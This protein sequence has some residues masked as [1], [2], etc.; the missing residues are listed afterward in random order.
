M[1]W[2]GK[3]ILSCRLNVANLRRSKYKIWR[4]NGKPSE[5]ENLHLQEKKKAKRHLRKT[6]RIEQAK[7]RNSL[8]ILYFDLEF[9]VAVL[10]SLVHTF[11]FG[12]ALKIALFDEEVIAADFMISQILSRI[13]QA[14]QRNKEKE[15]IMETKT[16]DMKLFHKLVR[17]NMFNTADIFSQN[18]LVP[19][20]VNFFPFYFRNSRFVI[21]LL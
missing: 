18:Y 12:F 19:F 6:I 21:F 11:N 7:Q 16:K 1:L 9:E 2:Y 15:L 14:K 17:N 5:V 20:L 4:D 8:Q 3:S 13:E 10:I